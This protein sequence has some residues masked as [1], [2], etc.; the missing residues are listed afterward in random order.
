[1][2]DQA[3]NDVGPVDRFTLP[4]DGRPPPP[5]FPRQFGNFL[6]LSPL[7]TG[8]MGEIFLGATGGVAGAVRLVVIKTLRPD[9]EKE[10]GYLQRFLDEARVVLQLQHPNIAQVYEVGDVDGAHFIA[11]EH[12][13]GTNL[14]RL[15]DVTAQNIPVPLAL[16]IMAETLSGLDSAHRHKHPLTGERLRVVH[17][18]VSPHNVMLSYDGEVKL[19]DF[20][21]ATSELK[22]E[23]TGSDVVMGKIAYMS[24]EQARGEPVDAQTDQFAAAVVLYEL[25]AGAR[26]YGDRSYRD[27]W[28]VAGNGE[29]Q[30]DLTRLAPEL[31]AIL[32]RALAFDASARF[33]S[34][35]EFADAL[36]EVLR[37]KYPLAGKAMLRDF[38]DEHLALDRQSSEA[39]LR[40]V[41]P[42]ALS[43]ISSSHPRSI[44]AMSQPP[45]TTP[46]NANVPSLAA[47]DD[48][49]A[50]VRKAKGASRL[51]LVAAAVAVVVVLAVVLALALRPGDS[52]PTDA[53]LA[54]GDMQ[55]TDA[56]PIDVPPMEPPHV[57]APPIEAPPVDP[58]AHATVHAA[59]I[60]A[61]PADGPKHVD[62]QAKKAA[63]P[64]VKLTAD[65]RSW[66]MERKVKVLEA[67]RDLKCAKGLLRVRA[68]GAELEPGVVDFCLGQIER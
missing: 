26:F 67:H 19:I 66:P 46:T 61:P 14:R 65:W 17:R 36:R 39:S 42:L 11:M 41:A 52:A 48:T 28:I 25:L 30:P 18:D 6:L 1:M 68:G 57:E 24:P 56:P 43:V 2:S 62:A 10:R 27:I 54:A 38:V 32:A 4:L 63:E 53:K 7:A 29:H 21:L 20:G 49:Q 34:C 23:Q 12:I 33:P 47:A 59:K 44:P 58:P 3:S 51:P 35:A 55:K 8:G 5:G 37:N 22:L 13:A 40:N 9:L 15:V 16:Y 45:P 64:S 31:H 60:E 50:V